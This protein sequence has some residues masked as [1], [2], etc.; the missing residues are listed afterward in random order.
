[1][2]GSQGGGAR[3][4]GE[5]GGAWTIV[6]AVAVKAVDLKASWEVKLMAFGDC[7]DDRKCI[8]VREAPTCDHRE[9][10]IAV[11]ITGM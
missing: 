6:T 3:R 8:G 4:G 5:H 1:M 10:R 9:Q 2:W 7:F 11:T